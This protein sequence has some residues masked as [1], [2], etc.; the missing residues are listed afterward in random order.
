MALVHQTPTHLEVEDKPFFGLGLKPFM[1]LV[2]G[3]GCA[4]VLFNLA[5]VW[6]P[7]L[8]RL[9]VVVLVVVIT[10]VVALFKPD[11]RPLGEW[12]SDRSN[13]YTRP[14]LAVFGL[15]E[16][17]QSQQLHSFSFNFDEPLPADDFTEQAQSQVGDLRAEGGLVKNSHTKRGG[18][19]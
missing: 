12:I 4:F 5:L 14:Q 8:M 18:A 3:I 9:M 13:F 2:G 7:F 6:L 19:R 15:L 10:L 17:P 11:K 1:T 16:L